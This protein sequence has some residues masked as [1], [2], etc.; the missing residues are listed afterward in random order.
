M[1]AVLSGDVDMTAVP[2]S[3]VEPYVKS[4]MVRALAVTSPKR[5]TVFA[6]VPSFVELGYDLDVQFLTAVVAPAGTP[7][8]IV[9]KIAADIRAVL[10]DPAFAAQQIDKFGF[11]AI[12]DDPQEFSD[13]L[14]KASAVYGARIGA[15]NVKLD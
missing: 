5:I 1:Q 11:T 4:N 14:A 13:Y 6:S 2:L 7:A 8:S 15:A 10:A 3:M 12:G 9:S